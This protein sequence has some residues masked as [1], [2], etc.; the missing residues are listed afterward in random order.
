MGVYQR[1]IVPRLVDSAM[2][3]QLLDH[4]RE[5]VIVA[6]KGEV[7]E[8]GVGSG[9]NLPLYGNAVHG[10]CAIEPSPELLRLAG[11]RAGASPVPVSLVRASAEQLPFEAAVFDTVVMT[12]TLCSIPQ[13]LPALIEIR[14]VLRP[15]GQLLFVEHGPVSRAQQRNIRW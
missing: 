3:N 4:Y 2:R 12:W 1:W 6:A 9:L 15:E 13:P 8:I 7:L 10:I 14:R 11:N 5:E